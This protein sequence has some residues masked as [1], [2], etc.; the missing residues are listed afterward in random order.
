M[1]QHRNTPPEGKM[2]TG[3]LAPD[4]IYIWDRENISV[5]VSPNG[6]LKL[7]VDIIGLR[8][9]CADNASR[10]VL[11]SFYTRNINMLIPLSNS[12]ILK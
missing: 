9:N 6:C 2:T 1:P 5:K 8:E 7:E 10:I 11:Q 3:D 4:L 12:I